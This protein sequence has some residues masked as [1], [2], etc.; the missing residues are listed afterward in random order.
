MTRLA[1]VFVSGCLNGPPIRFNTTN[2][3]VESQIWSRWAA[4]DRLVSL[5]PELAAGF[6]VPRP[7]AE[8]VDG[9]AT[10][11]LVG[12]A[13]VRE[14]TGVDVTDMFVRGAKLAVERA[15]AGGCVA[16]VLTD[17]SP[18]C[19]TTYIYDGTFEGGTTAGRGVAAQLLHERGIAVFSHEQLEDA[20][21]FIRAHDATA[22]P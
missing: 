8:I 19:G 1:R 17:G 5:C 6:G 11:V 16:A 7:P 12:T 2:V 4:E 22:P 14:D 9:D 20:D 10:A 21:R 3:E 15:V 13:R 18:T